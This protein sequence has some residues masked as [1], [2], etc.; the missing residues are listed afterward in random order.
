[1]K[2]LTSFILVL[3]IGCAGSSVTDPESAR[4][5]LQESTDR[6]SKKIP[7]ILE[8]VDE[9]SNETFAAPA[10]GYEKVMNLL[11][12]LG[13]QGI[14]LEHENKDTLEFLEQVFTSSKTH[15]RELERVYTG[16]KLSYDA[17]QKSLTLGEGSSVEQTLQF[18]QKNIPKRR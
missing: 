9:K 12:G 15:E 5:S 16:L 4:E 11:A 7:D 6:Q 13:Y 18:I 14:G 10:P 3:V 8:P 17:E 1:M 2:L